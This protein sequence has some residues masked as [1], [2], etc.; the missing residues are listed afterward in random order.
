MTGAQTI[1]FSNTNGVSLPHY[2]IRI[3]F[4]MILMDNWQ[5]S[6][7]ISATL[8]G[9]QTKTVSRNSRTSSEKVCGNSGDS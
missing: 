4:W 9:N 1:I 6:D 7:M 3:I 2:Q 8:E 5:G